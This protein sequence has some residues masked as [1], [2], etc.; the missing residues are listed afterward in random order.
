MSQLN[1]PRV[2]FSAERTLLAW[3]RT[4]LSM[5]AFGFVVERAGLLIRAVTP[6]GAHLAQVRLAFGL[7][8]LFIAVGCFAAGFSAWRYRRFLRTLTPEEFPPHY[9]ARWDFAINIFVVV[10]GLML[11]G[12]LIIGH[13]Q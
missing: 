8:L 1:D 2:L 12:V 3:N 6:D 11:M 9:G 4:A 13:M 10:L 7:G 5:M